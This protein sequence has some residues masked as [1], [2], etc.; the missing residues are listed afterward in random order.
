MDEELEGTNEEEVAELPE[1]TPEEQSKD[2]DNPA[3][4]A[5]AE[6]NRELKQYRIREAERNRKV[7][8]WAKQSGFSDIN[9]IDGYLNAIERQRQETE[10]ANLAQQYQTSQD[11]KILAQMAA[12]QMRQDPE[13]MR[14]DSLMNNVVNY[15][16]SQQASQRASQEIT[17]LNTEFGTNIRDINEVRDLPNG[18]KIIDYVANKG[19]S[20]AEAYALAN[21]T[22]VIKNATAAEKQRM[23]NQARGY[24]HVNENARGGN[25]DSIQVTDADIQRYSQFF[26]D[27]PREQIV[28]EI[29]QHKKDGIW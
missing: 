20:L 13:T 5:F 28:K 24:D 29:R 19:L 3:N 14:R 25:V 18:N 22:D 7:A 27:K 1:S 4:H 23:V 11:P 2:K 26:G 8:D 6:M 16:V 21:R 10:Q 12:N 9:D 15:V 17:E